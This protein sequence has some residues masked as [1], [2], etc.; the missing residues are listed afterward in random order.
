MATKKNSYISADLQF[1]ETQLEKWHN[2]MLDNPYDEVEDRKEMQMTKTGG[3]FYTVVQTKE[4]IQK[5]LRDT[6]KEYLAMLE[7]VEKLR[8][9]E[10]AKLETRGNSEISTL[11][12]DFLI[13]KK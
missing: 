8:E 6:L 2:Y 3:S 12:E 5:S 7:V 4:T 10:A 11:A 9:K 13:N 1:A